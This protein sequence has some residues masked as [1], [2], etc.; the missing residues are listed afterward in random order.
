M[1]RGLPEAPWDPTKIPRIQIFMSE[2]G[3]QVDVSGVPSS[4]LNG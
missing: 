4:Q 1:A 2:A 3:S